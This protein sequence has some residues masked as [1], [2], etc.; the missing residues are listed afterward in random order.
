MNAEAEILY[1]DGPE[2]ETTVNGGHAAG[3]STGAAV[4]PNTLASALGF[5]LDVDL[6]VAV[7]VGRVQLPV[8]RVMELRAGS[9]IELQR[10]AS[11]PVEIYAN[12]RCIGRGE[13]VVVGEQFGV[14][15]TELRA[16]S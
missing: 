3:R 9:V 5:V 13:I 7:E 1:P 4:D 6:N 15:V 14:R 11:D 2:V 8:R 10:S 16:S 12:N